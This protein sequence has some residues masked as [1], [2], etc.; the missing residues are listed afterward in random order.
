MNKY[1]T[2]QHTLCTHTKHVN[3][4]KHIMYR[5]TEYLQKNPHNVQIHNILIYK[6][7]LCTH[8]QHINRYYVHIH[9]INRVPDK[10]T[11][12]TNTKHNTTHN[13]QIH[14]TLT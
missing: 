3:I 5:F 10:Y 7:T 8:T 2:E 13:V 11:L 14:N 6:H 9:N 12:C 4:N 1:T